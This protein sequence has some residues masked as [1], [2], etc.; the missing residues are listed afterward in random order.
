MA[1]RSDRRSK[2]Q[3]SRTFTIEDYEG[4]DPM[5]VSAWP[6]YGEGVVRVCFQSG[7]PIGFHIEDLKEILSEI[8][9][10]MRGA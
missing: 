3:V 6:E 10:D 1:E 8:E 4:G 9:K 5:S 2:I 7:D